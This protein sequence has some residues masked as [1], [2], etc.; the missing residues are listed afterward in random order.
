MSTSSPVH[1]CAYIALQ[2]LLV[3]SHFC[4][5]GPDHGRGYARGNALGEGESR[6]PGVQCV[7]CVVEGFWGGVR[8]VPSVCAVWAAVGS[9]VLLWCA[10]LYCAKVCYAAVPCG[11]LFALWR[12]QSTVRTGVQHNPR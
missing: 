4:S 11:V 3:S 9:V 2:Y 5:Q 12:V 10:V 1:H 6:V 7:Q 8:A